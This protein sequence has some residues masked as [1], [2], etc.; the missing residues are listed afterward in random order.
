MQ[1]QILIPE[2]M[3]FTAR[4]IA[5]MLQGQVD[6]NPDVTVGSLARIEEGAPGCISFLANPKYTS[7]IYT[8]NSSIVIVNQDFIVEKAIT[9]T[10]VRV[11]DA[12]SAF[13]RLLE[14]YNQIKYNKTGISVHS[15]I[16]SSAVIGSNVYIGDFVS[17]GDNV[18][19]G[20]H[21][22]LYPHVYLG[23]NV[24]VGDHSILF[25][26]VKVY[27]DNTI[28]RRCTLHSG[29]VI[30][31][32]GF[33]F[34]PQTDQAYS[35]LPQIGNV[36]IEDEV[37]IGANTTIDRATLGSTLIR[38]GVKLDNLIQIAHNV[39]I[40]ENTVIAAQTGV[41]GSTRVGANC[42]IGGQAGI[43]GHI[44]IADGVKIAA[45]SGIGNTVSAPGAILQGSPAF[46][47]ARYQRSYVVYRKLPEIATLVDKLQKRIKAL[48]SR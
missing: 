47:R 21:V 43:V 35:K 48:E 27:S 28:G 2:Q 31:A 23:D 46:D 10:L 41:S 29:A 6:G 24:K 13:G 19:I 3:N 30:G 39:Q 34:A 44:Q 42:M 12:Y 15:A 14:L 17:V 38:K 33:G 20:D 36:V 9:A 16:A 40:G 32:D 5:E 26:G 8:T 11:A 22:K 18:V 4:Q 1:P 7:F 25:S 37:E 45:Q